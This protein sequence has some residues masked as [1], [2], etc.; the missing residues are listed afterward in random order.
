M[1]ATGV[2]RRNRKSRPPPRRA[3]RRTASGQYCSAKMATRETPGPTAARPRGAPPAAPSTTRPRPATRASGR[4]RPGPPIRTARMRTTMLTAA[5]GSAGRA[6]GEHP[7]SVHVRG[8]QMAGAPE[9]G[10]TGRRS[11]PVLPCDTRAPG[12]PTIPAS[13]SRAPCSRAR[14]TR[15]RMRNAQPAPTTAQWLPPMLR[16]T[17]M[18]R[19]GRRDASLSS[20]TACSDK[21]P[22]TVGP[23]AS[24]A[25][26]AQTAK[27]RAS[28]RGSGARPLSPARAA[29]KRACASVPVC[30]CASL[31]ENRASRRNCRR[32]PAG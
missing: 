29:A 15:P 16:P 22:P 32:G 17:A 14:S 2:S 13:V 10:T 7:C 25:A 28:P 1:R 4:S 26:P 23:C 12:S 21:P 8:T 20:V 31:S 19:A 18:A 3:A 27:R 9:Y 6:S 11:R 5:T 30:G 24:P